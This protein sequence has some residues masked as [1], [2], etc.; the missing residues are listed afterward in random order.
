MIYNGTIGVAARYYGA[1]AIT[2]VYKGAK[3][4]WEAVSSC[5]GGGMWM[6]DRAWKDTDGWKE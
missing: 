3:L 1:K 2:A 6:R 4:V 5:F